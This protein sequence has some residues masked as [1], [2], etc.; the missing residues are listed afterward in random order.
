MK[1]HE[2]IMKILKI[3]KIMK[4]IKIM[5]IM[6]KNAT[7]PANSWAPEGCQGGETPGLLQ[8]TMGT[9]EPCSDPGSP[10]TALCLK[11][12]ISKIMKL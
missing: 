8:V 1:N 7:L 6:K 9:S 10:H 12:S 3:M 5:K 4:I 2:K 11:T